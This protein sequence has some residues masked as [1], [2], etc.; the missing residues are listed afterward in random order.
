M[1]P[2]H[3]REVKSNSI[4]IFGVTCIL[5]LSFSG[6]AWLFWTHEL[7]YQLPTNV[8][9][10]YKNVETGS[11]LS[12]PLPFE[13]GYSKPLFLHFFNPDCPCS[14]FNI[15]HFKELV[16]KYAHVVDFAIVAMTQNEYTAAEIQDRFNLDLPVSFDT[17][18]AK[19]CGVYSTPQAVIVDKRKLFFR[20]NYNKSRYCT[21]CQ[22]PRLPPH[23]YPA[24][25]TYNIRLI[26]TDS[27]T[28]NI[29]DTA[30]ATI[31]LLGKPV[32]GIGTVSP[33]PPVPN[34]ALTFQNTSSS[35]AIRFKWLFG[36]GDS[37]LTGHQLPV[38]HEYNTADSFL[39]LLIAYNAAGC[40]DTAQRWVTT[41]VEPAVDVP[42]A[43]TPLSGGVNSVVFARGFGIAS[44]HFTIWNRWGQKVFET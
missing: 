20:G 28:C 44:L 27:G 36:D 14:K 23:L 9:P 17:T 21:S 6:I 29:V 42:N 40:P 18:I 11:L 22:C 26:A 2:T 8:P 37:L 31:E 39:V 32:A 41:L 16:G 12:L 1:T 5:A 38:R 30:Y 4:R 33:Q 13:A 24:P 10:N 25:G 3:S 15:S 34:T 35:D 19:K 7:K 43:F